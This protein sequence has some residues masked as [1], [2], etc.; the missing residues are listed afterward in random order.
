MPPEKE[1]KKPFKCEI[2]ETS[3]AL[4]QQLR[5]HVSTVHAEEILSHLFDRIK[6]IHEESPILSCLKCNHTFKS[7][8]R[9]ILH[10]REAHQEKRS[11]KVENI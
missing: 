7:K 6:Q 8:E 10:D 9:L 3:F 4:K 2:C 11:Y 1:R 5:K